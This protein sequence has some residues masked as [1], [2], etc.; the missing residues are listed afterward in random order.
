MI[1]TLNCFVQLTHV[2]LSAEDTKRGLF[3]KDGILEHCKK[4]RKNARLV[5]LIISS[6]TYDES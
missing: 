2:F 6:S 5:H 3:D 4:S 1:S